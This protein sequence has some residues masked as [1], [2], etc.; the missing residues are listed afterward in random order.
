M[1]GATS[2]E[3]HIARST[4][5]QQAS[6]GV[7]VVAMLIV[8]TL[9]GRQL[10]LREF[11]LFGL[12]IALASYMLVLQASVEGAA[13]R[14][15]ALVP[16]GGPP[17]DRLFSTI[18]AL[19]AGFG[20]IAGAIIAG[21]GVALVGVLRIDADLERTAREGFVALGSV[22]AVGWPFRAYL[23]ALRG[24]QQFV[25]ASLAE[26]VA[27]IAYVVLMIA[28]IVAGA[29]LWAVIAVGGSLP[30]LLGLGSL[31]M[32][33]IVRAPFRFR[34]A[35][36]NTA[37]AREVL[38]FSAYLSAIG[39]ADLITYSTDRIVLAAF[40]STAVVGLFEG[41][42]RPHALVR[43]LHGTLVVTIVPVASGYIA[44]GD[45]ERLHDLL[46]RGTRYVMAIVAPVTVVLMVISAP[47]LE[48]WLGP[49]FRV[50]APAMAI[51]LSYWVVNAATGIGGAMLVARGR[52]AELTKLAWTVAL[53]NLA[54]S[55][56]LTPWLGLDG[57]ALG[58]A[59][60]YFLIFP[61][62]VHLVLKDFPVG[63]GRFVRTAILPAYVT[64]AATAV[65]V[66]LVRLLVEPEGIAAVGLTAVGGLAFAF[67][68]YAAACL[69]PAERAM[70]RSL[71]R[72]APE[73]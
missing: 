36:V 55:L 16:Q 48:A 45:E 24:S 12:L 13:V 50:A 6:Q 72:R 7:G 47:L 18:L 23:D 20:L 59:I 1:S 67:T 25:A 52:A 41:V 9:L 65:V 5:A 56:A 73:R 40:R 69:A 43:Q 27:N 63:L 66:G 70:L 3:R 54:L 8:I 51:L 44:A 29:P 22:T 57:V 2:S 10:S 61:V 58:T 33:K 64:A 37:T 21:A 34:V 26:V 19:Y 15:I 60:P 31:A 49:R 32:L 17:R 28:L 14:A 46:L 39:I 42:I 35:E 30:I 11:G 62:V 38:G 71:L 68:F 4:L 53:M